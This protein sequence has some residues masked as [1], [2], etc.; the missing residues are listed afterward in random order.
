M[1]PADG[2]TLA[3]TGAVRTITL[4]PLEAATGAAN[5]TLTV[6]DAEGASGHASFRVTVNARSASIQDTALTTFAKGGSGRG[7]R[8]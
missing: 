6:I 8:S 5:V 7:R 2:I 1:V 4:T 3:G